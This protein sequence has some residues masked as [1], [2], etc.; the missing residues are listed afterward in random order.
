M[1]EKR[2]NRENGKSSVDPYINDE[3]YVSITIV[4]EHNF[5][6][7]SFSHIITTSSPSGLYKQ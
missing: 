1:R 4:I 2:E 7:K 5:S 3:N 6:S